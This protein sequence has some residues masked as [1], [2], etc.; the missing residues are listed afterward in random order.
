[1]YFPF[2]GVTGHIIVESEHRPLGAVGSQVGN[3]LREEI[4]GPSI[5]DL[6]REARRVVRLIG[7]LARDATGAHGVADELQQCTISVADA[8]DDIAARAAMLSAERHGT[9][10]VD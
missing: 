3:D 4:E 2:R 1:V 10:A 9:L 7:S 6:E 5:R 8:H